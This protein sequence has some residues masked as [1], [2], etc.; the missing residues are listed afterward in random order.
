MNNESRPVK[1]IPCVLPHLFLIHSFSTLFIALYIIAFVKCSLFIMFKINFGFSYTC[2]LLNTLKQLKYE[3][4]VYLTRTT[5]DVM[6][7]LKLVC[8][9]L[10]SVILHNS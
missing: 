1:A 9:T 8:F 10:P 2:Y 7:L 5:A 6:R 4:V 3:T